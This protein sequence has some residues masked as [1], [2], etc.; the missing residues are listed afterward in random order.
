MSDDAPEKRLRPG[1][2][3]ILQ[4]ARGVPFE[5]VVEKVEEGTILVDASGA[6]VEPLEP[7]ES[8]HRGVGIDGFGVHE[9]E[10]QLALLQPSLQLQAGLS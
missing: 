2:R 8:W 3:L 6:P 10:T 5:V 7:V 9:P 1:S 4:D